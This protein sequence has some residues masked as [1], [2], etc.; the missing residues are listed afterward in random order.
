MQHDGCMAGD[1]GVGFTDV[2]SG[3]PGTQSSQFDSATFQSWGSGFYSRLAAHVARA[4][5]SIGCVANQVINVIYC[6]LCNA[7]MLDLHRFTVNDIVT[8]TAPAIYAR[9]GCHFLSCPPAPPGPVKEGFGLAMGSAC[10]HSCEMY[11]ASG[12]RFRQ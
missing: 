4:C 3:I 6:Y 7:V 10:R 12:H 8:I 1:A 2:G 9:R 11:N 5:D